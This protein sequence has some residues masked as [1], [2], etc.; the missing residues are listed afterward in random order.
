MVASVQQFTQIMELLMEM[1]QNTFTKYG[2]FQQ[3]W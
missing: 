1:Q 2:K 3:S